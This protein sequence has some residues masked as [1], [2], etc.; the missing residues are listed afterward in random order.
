MRPSASDASNTGYE[1]L[2]VNIW[3]ADETYTAQLAPGVNEHSINV[4]VHDDTLAVEGA[5]VSRHRMARVW[6]AG[7]RPTEAAAFSAASLPARVDLSDPI[8]WRANT[9]RRVLLELLISGVAAWES[10]RA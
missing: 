6:L 7:V 3:A 4:T 10:A 5:W 2:P 1:S 9:A 8:G